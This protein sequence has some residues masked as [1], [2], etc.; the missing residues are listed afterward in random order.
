MVVT[1][2]CAPRRIWKAADGGDRARGWYRAHD[3]DVASGARALA[4]ASTARRAPASGEGSKRINSTARITPD[5]PTLEPHRCP[6][7]VSGVC[8]ERRGPAPA[9]GGSRAAREVFACVLG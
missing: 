2:Q 5:G 4:T 8:T 3:L 6:M 1:S 9:A 7:L